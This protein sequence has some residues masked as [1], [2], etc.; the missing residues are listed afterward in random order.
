[1]NQWLRPIANVAFADMTLP[2]PIDEN[3]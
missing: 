2:P 1:M 3:C